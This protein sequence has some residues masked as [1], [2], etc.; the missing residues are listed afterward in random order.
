MISII[1]PCYNEEKTIETFYNAITVEMDKLKEEFEV[2]FINDGS[3]DKTKEIATEI[4]NKDTRIKLIS[5]SRNFG[6]QAAIIAGL[7]NCKGD[8]ALELDV[9]LQDPVEVIP[10]MLK[11]WREGYEVIHGR[12]KKR[13][14]ESIFKKATAYMYYKFLAKIN[15]REIPRNTGD[16][17][18]YDRKVVDTICALPEHDKYLR[19]LAAWVGFKQTFVDFDRKERSAGETHY[20]M[21]KMLKLAKAGI[22]SNSNFPLTLSMKAGLFSCFASC[23]CFITFIILACCKISLPIVAWLFPTITLLAGLGFIFNGISNLYLEKT[24][25]EVKNRPDYIIDETINI[26]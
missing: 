13:A 12:R 21:K 2:I 3:K 7:R 19:G 5:F 24:Y 20:T 11:L 10:E 18:L 16:F 4:C 17:K 9:D 23:A 8:C 15:E 26:K 14:G 1:V 22:L 25:T 6:Q